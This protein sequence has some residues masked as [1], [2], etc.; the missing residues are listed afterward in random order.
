MSKPR[1]SGSK[2]KKF[3]GRINAIKIEPT[4]SLLYQAGCALQN[5]ESRVLEMID[6]ARAGKG[7]PE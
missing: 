5:H 7:G 2:S 6:A 3:W 1:Y 4:H